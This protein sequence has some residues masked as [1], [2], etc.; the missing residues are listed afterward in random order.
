MRTV[1]LGAGGQLAT[2]LERAISDW[3]VVP[4]RH[5]DLDVCDHEAVWE[6]LS[7]I[8]PEAVINTAAF[9]RVNDCEDQVEKAFRV[10]TYA[11][12]NLAQVCADLGCKLMHVSTDY[13][14]GGEKRTPYTEDDLPN[15]LNV[16]GVSKLAG[17]YFVRNVCPKH[18]VVRTSGLYGLA[19]SSGKGG[20]FVETMLRLAKAGTPIRVVD[21]QVL[22]PTYTF[23]LAQSMYTIL[24][25]D[26]FGQYH[27][28]NQGE[29]SWYEFAQSIF[30]IEELH[31]NLM[32]TTSEEFGARAMRP[33][34]S[35]LASMRTGTAPFET[36]P[37]W[38]QALQSYLA[39][40]SALAGG[41]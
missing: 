21:D 22:S 8:Q 23:H 16:Y 32:A 31:V 24:E 28:T 38:R 25:T 7:E 10:N 26:E 12:R 6:R 39:N 40:R 9:H 41:L 3:E 11:V 34:Y 17:E 37:H 5:A 4:L 2:D 33:Q 1:I 35:S 15:P 19:G 36:L 20:N 30:E 27:L 13:V 18:F 14:F 29:C